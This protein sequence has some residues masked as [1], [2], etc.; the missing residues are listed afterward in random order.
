MQ[1]QLE[2]ADRE[3]PMK[4]T[5]YEML[6][7]Y[8]L[9]NQNRFYRVAYSYVKNEEDALDAVQNAVCKALESYRN[10]KNTEAVRTWFYRILIN[11]SINI[12]RQ[13]KKFLLSEDYPG[14]ETA[15]EEQGYEPQEDIAKELEE[16]EEDTQ[17]I[18]KLRFFEELS[19]KEISE[20]TGLN[21]STVKTKLYRGLKLLK[22]S[23][24]E[25]DE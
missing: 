21:L 8:I 22:E 5:L 4:E 24:Q 20:I 16:L 10:L 19:L 23:V 25:V 14:L 17:Q 9:E 7:S 1:R 6:I 18:I 11:E 2:A 15:Y 13:R 3:V 12:T